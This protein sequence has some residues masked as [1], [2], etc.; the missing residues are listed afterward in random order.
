MPLGLPLEGSARL[1]IS[2][3]SRLHNSIIFRNFLSSEKPREVGTAILFPLISTGDLSISWY[4]CLHHSIRRWE[5]P[6]Q[7]CP[8]L[9]TPTVA[10]ICASRPE[11][12]G[13]AASQPLASPALPH[14][15]QSSPGQ[16]HT[17]SS[18]V[19]DGGGT[20][21]PCASPRHLP[22]IL[23]LKLISTSPQVGDLSADFLGTQPLFIYKSR[24]WNSMA[25]RM[26]F[27]EQSENICNVEKDQKDF[28]SSSHQKEYSAFWCFFFLWSNIWHP[29]WPTISSHFHP[30]LWESCPRRSNSW[31]LEECICMVANWYVILGNLRARPNFLWNWQNYNL[32]IRQLSRC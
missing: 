8:G 4:Y 21:W 24:Q 26:I 18:S 11:G 27:K 31:L 2:D 20:E 5:G 9:L 32:L 28:L 7:A 19:E 15:S 1:Q 12:G 30:I 14:Q 23:F 3:T 17:T 6:W 10:G 16:W 29:V 25:T 13:G 22:S